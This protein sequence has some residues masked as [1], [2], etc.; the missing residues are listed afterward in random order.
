MPRDL[1]SER[2]IIENLPQLS[3]EPDSGAT[4]ASAS[5]SF[6]DIISGAPSAADK[7]YF[8]EP[9]EN[10]SKRDELHPY[11]Q[12]LNVTNVDSCVALEA[13]A[14]PPHEAATK[15]KFEYR[16]SV[17][18]ELSLGMFTATPT[19][20]APANLQKDATLHTA[21]ST[22]I[23]HVVSTKTTNDVVS[24]EDMDL[25]KNWQTERHSMSKAGHKEEGRTIALHSLAVLPAYQKIGLG[26]T[27]LKSYV[28]R[29]Q[30]A[31]IADRIVLLAHD[32]LV[33]FYEKHGFEKKGKSKATY[34]GG[35]WVDMVYE[36]PIDDSE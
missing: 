32:E 18:G 8:F 10:Q 1:E 19:K 35:N 7:G 20:D 17:C 11:V 14:F 21:S 2:E 25:P 23:A 29:M 26:S 34:G 6:R 4:P 16:F 27:I 3:R 28:Q 36:F 30:N 22:L 24:D 15:E 13:A 12:T 5:M 33:P 9:D 31:E